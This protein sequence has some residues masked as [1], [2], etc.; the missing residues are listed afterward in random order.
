MRKILMVGTATALAPF[1]LDV[2]AHVDEM[3]A[4]SLAATGE[5]A[6]V[7]ARDTVTAAGYGGLLA[8]QKQK[9]TQA[10]ADRTGRD[11]APGAAVLLPDDDVPQAALGAVKPRGAALYD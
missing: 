11:Y 2:R 6:Y 1:A 4:Y 10:W 7:D 3:T 9:A 5:L 8:F